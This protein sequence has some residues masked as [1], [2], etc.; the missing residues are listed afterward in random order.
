MSAKPT[1]GGLRPILL[2][3]GTGNEEAA[4]EAPSRS[5]L[6]AESLPPSRGKRLGAKIRDAPVIFLDDGVR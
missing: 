5:A 2:D 4:A 1:K 3:R 6:R